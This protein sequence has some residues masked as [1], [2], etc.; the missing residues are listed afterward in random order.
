MIGKLAVTAAA[1]PILHQDIKRSRRSDT[2]AV[3]LEDG[4][5]EMF[6]RNHGIYGDRLPVD[7]YLAKARQTDDPD[8][9]RILIRIRGL[10][11]ADRRR[12]GNSVTS[13][14]VIAPIS[15]GRLGGRG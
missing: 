12:A 3:R 6:G 9:Q 7:A 1:A 13:S 15:G 8:G 14:G 2:L 5:L 11:H 4:S 10:R